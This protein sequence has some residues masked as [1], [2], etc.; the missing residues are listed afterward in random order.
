MKEKNKKREQTNT[1][2]DQNTRQDLKVFGKSYHIE[3]QYSPQLKN[4]LLYIETVHIK[5]PIRVNHGSKQ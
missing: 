5:D 2:G 3:F 4:G 1:T